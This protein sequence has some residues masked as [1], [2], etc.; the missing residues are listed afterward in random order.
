MFYHLT[1]VDV[2]TCHRLAGFLSDLLNKQVLS[3]SWDGRPFCH[4]RRRLK[5]GGCAPLR[6]ELGLHLKQRGLGRGLPP[7]QVAS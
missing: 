7:Y 1:L 5:I 4:N 3:S 2:A 6:G